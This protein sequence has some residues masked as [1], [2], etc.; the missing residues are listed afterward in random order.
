MANRDQQRESGGSRTVLDVLKAWERILPK[1]FRPIRRILLSFKTRILVSTLMV[2]I[3]GVLCIAVLLQVIVFPRLS[4]D[5]AVVFKLKAIHLISGLVVIIVSWM[6][7]EFISKR[8]TRPLLQLTARADQISREAAREYSEAAGGTPIDSEKLRPE[9]APAG[10][11][12]ANDGDLSSEADEIVQ[13]TTSFDR[14]LTQ[15]KAAEARLKESEEKYRFLFDNA[16]SPIFVIDASDMRIL[17]VNARAEE[18]YQ[19][20]REKI[21]GMAFPDLEAPDRIGFGARFLSRAAVFEES[22]HPT[23]KHRRRDGSVFKIDMEARLTTF[24]NMPAIIAAVWDVTDKVERE[25]KWVQTGKMAVLGEMATGIAHELNQPLNVI[26]LGADILVK[27]IRNGRNPSPQELRQ[28]AEEL[29]SNVERATKIIN[30]LR[31]FGRK[32]PESMNPVNV[33]DPLRGVFTLL[34]SQLRKRGIEF[35]LS[36]DENL[37]RIMGDENRLEQVFINLVINA[38][39]AINRLEMESPKEAEA[40]GKLLRVKSFLEEGKVTVTVSDTGVGVPEELKSKIFEPFFTTK[41]VGE[42]TGVGLSISYGIIKE[43]NGAVEV[44]G[45]DDLGATFRVTLPPLNESAESNY[46]QGSRDR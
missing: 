22:L 32:A 30:H 4:G 10:G 34:G 1:R 45:G 37:P 7:I 11:G 9:S 46:D 44:D 16:P 15:L 8:I 6:F 5:P 42:G 40:R 43:H 23:V 19:Y 28:T 18:E 39:D 25:A 26:R 21:L 29:C 3:G 24:K 31:D 27:S 35:E 36:L 33:N 12:S 2:V 13:L 38:R 41:K 14:M 17:D 20:S